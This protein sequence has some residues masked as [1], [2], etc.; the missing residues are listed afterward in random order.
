MPYA[1]PSCVRLLKNCDRPMLLARNTGGFD[2][3]DKLLLH[4][5]IEKDQRDDGKQR[6]CELITL[7]EPVCRIAE[8]RGEGSAEQGIKG[9]QLQWQSLEIAADEQRHLRRFIP[10]PHQRKQQTK[11]DGGNCHGQR[12]NKEHL[13]P[14]GAVQL[15]CLVIGLGHRMEGLHENQHENG[16]HQTLSQ[17]GR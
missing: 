4:H 12:H 13:Q 6:G 16:A 3:L 11:H 17:R 9:I 1:T 15:G 8:I 2:S 14:A 7:V 10:V 5:Q